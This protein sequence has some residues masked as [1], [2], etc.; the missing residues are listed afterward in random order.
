MRRMALSRLGH[1]GQG[2]SLFKAAEGTVEGD[3]SR[4]LGGSQPR[5]PRE[6]TT[7]E[8]PPRGGRAGS[9]L[10]LW[11]ATGCRLGQVH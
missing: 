3:V 11:A 4:G 7:V 6:G 8:E 5:G 2:L 1:A 10:W 9:L